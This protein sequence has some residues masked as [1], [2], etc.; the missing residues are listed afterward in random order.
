MRELT[1]QVSDN[2]FDVLVN[3]LKT[4][5]Y[6]KLPKDLKYESETTNQIVADS[7][8]V[9]HR[10]PM[11][12]EDLGVMDNAP[13][14]NEHIKKHHSIKWENFHEIIEMFKDIPLE[15]YLEEH[16]ISHND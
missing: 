3:F 10:T 5:P 8:A 12:F 15:N 2:Q 11:N 14:D 13:W 16:T 1:V 6:V 4:L 7:A 9:Y